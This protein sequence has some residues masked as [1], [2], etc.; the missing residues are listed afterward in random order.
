MTI[1]GPPGGDGVGKHQRIET[2]HTPQE[3]FASAA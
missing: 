3:E 1:S 2:T